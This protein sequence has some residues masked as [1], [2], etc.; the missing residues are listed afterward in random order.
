[1]HLT[2]GYELMKSIPLIPDY[3]E[4]TMPFHGGNGNGEGAVVGRVH[5]ILTLAFICFD[6][7]LKPLF[8]Q[9]E[10]QNPSP[11]QD[12]D[13]YVEGLLRYLQSRGR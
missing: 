9:A 11:V 5:K 10:R 8:S 2:S 1:M 7:W 3:T 13:P 6:A 4:T 12:C